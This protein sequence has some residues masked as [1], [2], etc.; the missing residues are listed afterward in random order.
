[1]SGLFHLAAVQT[2]FRGR[3]LAYHRKERL[4]T[5]LRVQARFILCLQR[6]EMRSRRAKRTRSAYRVIPFW[7][8]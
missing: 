2:P 1:M 8:N 3:R 5:H 6:T 7:R 4:V